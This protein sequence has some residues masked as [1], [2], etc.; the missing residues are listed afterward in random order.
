MIP[1]TRPAGRLDAEKRRGDR[2]IVG[3]A[4]RP[5]E[6]LVMGASH[7]TTGRLVYL[8]EICGTGLAKAVSAED[9]H[10]TGVAA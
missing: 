8:V 10:Q 2:V 4:G 5:H 7:L 9:M 3:F 6:A 1:A